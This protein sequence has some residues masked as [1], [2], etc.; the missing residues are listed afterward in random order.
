MVSRVSAY[1]LIMLVMTLLFDFNF[2]HAESFG[3]WCESEILVFGLTIIT[4][5]AIDLFL[6]DFYDRRNKNVVFLPMKILADVDDALAYECLGSSY[7]LV[8]GDRSHLQYSFVSPCSG[9]LD[10]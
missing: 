2:Q 5:P 6:H 4:V 8:G 7:H 3:D 10:S 9:V 1:T